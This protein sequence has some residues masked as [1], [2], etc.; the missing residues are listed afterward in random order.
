MVSDHSCYRF[1]FFKQKTAYEV[2]ISD[3]SSDVCSS[4]LSSMAP[5]LKPCLPAIIGCAKGIR[6]NCPPSVCN[7]RFSIFPATLRD[8]LLTTASSARENPWFF[9]ETPCLRQVAGASSKAPP[10]KWWILWV[11]YAFC[12]QKR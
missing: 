5:R 11:N 2:R 8:I 4:D 12:R 1:F 9:A 3:W 7:L 6:Y 10:P